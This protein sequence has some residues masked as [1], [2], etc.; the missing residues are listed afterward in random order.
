MRSG[1]IRSPKST[2]EDKLIW[3]IGGDG[4]TPKEATAGMIVDLMY[5]CPSD[6]SSPDRRRRPCR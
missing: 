4:A 3:F 1:T 2:G 5:R 6:A